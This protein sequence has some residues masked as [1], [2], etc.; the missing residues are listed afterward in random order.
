MI[1]Q[2]EPIFDRSSIAEDLKNYALSDGW[3]TEHKKTKEFEQ[4]IAKFLRIPHCCVV[5]NG[6]ISLSLALLAAGVV[7]GDHVLVPDLTMIATA[8]AVQLIGAVPILVDVDSNLCMDVSSASDRITVNTSAVLY[9]TLNGRASNAEQIKKLASQKGISYIEDD[10][11]SLGSKYLD[12]SYIGTKANIASFSFS[13]PKII[14]TGQGGCLVTNGLNLYTNIKKLRDF[15]RVAGGSDLFTCFGIN[16]KF[17]EM[18]A[19]LGLNQMR[20]IQKRIEIKKKMYK[21]Y[22]DG[23]KDIV[24]FI[25]TN[26]EFTIPWFMDIFTDKRDELADHL[27]SFGIQT[28]N[29]YP[30]IHSLPWIYRK[31]EY[32]TATRASQRGLWLP[33]SMNLSDLDLDFIIEKIRKFYT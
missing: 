1:P 8:N 29:M 2:Y 10:A 27:R 16:S 7:A 23:L 22:F 24:E 25:P 20:T 9:V 26:L 21:Q 28:R 18:Q 5:N 11:Q 6:T 30:A 32:A 13:V 4:S 3:F 19:V 33:S 14:T 15:G 31:G 12:G 17:T